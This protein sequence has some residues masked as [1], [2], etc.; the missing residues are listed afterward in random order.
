MLMVYSGFRFVRHAGA[1]SIPIAIVNQ[2]R[3]RADS[4]AALRV[5]ADCA[6]VLPRACAAL[7][8]QVGA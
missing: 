1:R 4:L 5:D 2:G 6:H 7:E 8:E 3:T